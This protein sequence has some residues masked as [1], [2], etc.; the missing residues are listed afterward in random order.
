MRFKQAKRS[1]HVASARP[2]KQV[3]KHRLRVLDQRLLIPIEHLAAHGRDD[4]AQLF[5]TAKAKRLEVLNEVFDRFSVLR[6]LDDR[7]WRERFDVFWLGAETGERLEPGLQ[8]FPVGVD[9]PESEIGCR[10]STH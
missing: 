1:K 10:R 8:H 6:R 3:R 2:P 5:L 7:L 9:A 4:G